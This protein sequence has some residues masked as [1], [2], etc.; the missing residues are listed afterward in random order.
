MTASAQTIKSVNVTNLDTT[1]ISVLDAHNVGKLNSM[2]DYY[3][4]A[5]TDIDYVGDLILLGPIDSN[6]IITSIKIFV[7]TAL[8][9]N[10]SKTLAHNIGFYYSGKNNIVSGVAQT[11]GT[12][13]SATAIASA[14]TVCQML[15][16]G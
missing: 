13:V 15:P 10:G 8:D 1:P 12:A 9:T 4:V 6:A 7:S 16:I 11:E 3:T 14:S 2:Q 5:L